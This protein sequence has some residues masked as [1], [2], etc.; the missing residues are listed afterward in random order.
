MDI[1]INRSDETN[2]QQDLVIWNPEINEFIRVQFI[3]FDSI[4][5]PVYED[6]YIVSHIRGHAAM[7]WVEQKLIW[8]EYNQLTLYSV[9]RFV[10]DSY[11]GEYIRVDLE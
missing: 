3:G 5:H 11:L 7:Y 10:L 2:P 4:A 1:L 9:D 8:S 6:G